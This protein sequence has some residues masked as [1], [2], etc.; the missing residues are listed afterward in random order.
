MSLSLLVL[1]LGIVFALFMVEQMSASTYDIMTGIVAKTQE[2]CFG[3]RQKRFSTTS[4]Y[5]LHTNYIIKETLT[6]YIS[7][8]YY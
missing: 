6:K 4:L 3:I 5:N 2:G 8:T 1:F 7:K